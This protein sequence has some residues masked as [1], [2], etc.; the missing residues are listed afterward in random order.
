MPLDVPRI[1]PELI[2]YISQFLHTDITTLRSLALTS[3]IWHAASRPHLFHRITFDR[4]RTQKETTSLFEEF[5]D[6][7]PG[8]YPLIRVVKVDLLPGPME[9][10]MGSEP[11]FNEVPRI[12]RERLP[13]VHSLEVIGLGYFLGKPPT[14]EFFK[15]L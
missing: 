7:N 5:L 4:S 2:F 9:R 3:K 8:I 14:E 12:I 6:S 1:F 15:S 13:N 11:W 10:G